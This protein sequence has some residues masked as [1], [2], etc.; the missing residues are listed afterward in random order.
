MDNR[1]S[2]KKKTDLKEKSSHRKD[3]M[4]KKNY[5]Q[6]S[7]DFKRRQ[8]NSHDRQIFESKNKLLG[9]GSSKPKQLKVHKVSPQEKV[10]TPF[11]NIS[12]GEDIIVESQKQFPKNLKQKN[13]FNQKKVCFAEHLG[14][15]KSKTK[16]R[17]TKKVCS[18][19]VS[20]KKLSKQMSKVKYKSNF[21]MSPSRR[22]FK[23]KMDFSPRKLLSQTRSSFGG[24]ELSI[25]SQKR[26]SNQLRLNNLESKKNFCV[27]MTTKEGRF[28]R[29]TPVGCFLSNTFKAGK[30]N[31]NLLR[32]QFGNLR[33]SLGIKTQLSS[34]GKPV[35]IYQDIKKS[36]KIPKHRNAF[37]KKT[38]V[39]EGKSKEKVASKFAKKLK[40]EELETNQE[41]LLKEGLLTKRGCQSQDQTG[42]SNISSVNINQIN[43]NN[44][45]TIDR[46]F[47]EEC[48]QKLINNLGEIILKSSFENL[49]V[50]E[51]ETSGNQ[52]KEAIP[53]QQRRIKGDLD[54]ITLKNNI[55]KE[56]EKS[57]KMRSSSNKKSS[58]IKRRSCQMKSLGVNAMNIYCQDLENSATHVDRFSKTSTIPSFQA[59]INKENLKTANYLG[60]SEMN[61]LCVD[62]SEIPTNQDFV[63]RGSSSKETFELS[64]TLNQSKMASVSELIGK[65]E[66][67]KLNVHL[68]NEKVCSPQQQNLM[69]GRV[70]QTLVTEPKE[71]NL[72]SNDRKTKTQFVQK[73][74]SVQVKSN[75]K[76]TIGANEENVREI[77]RKLFTQEPTKGKLRR[78]RKL[79]ELKESKVAMTETFTQTKNV[80][81]KIYERGKEAVT[82]S[83]GR[84]NTDTKSLLETLD[85]KN[86]I[87]KKEPALSELDIFITEIH[88]KNLNRI[89]EIIPEKRKVKKNQIA[90]SLQISANKVDT[91]ELNE[92]V[93]YLRKGLSNKKKDPFENCQPTQKFCLMSHLTDSNQT[94]QRVPSQVIN[95]SN[96][97]RGHSAL[98]TNF[99]MANSHK[100][101]PEED[102]NESSTGKLT[103]TPNT[104]VNRSRKINTFPKSQKQTF[105][106]IPSPKQME[107]KENNIMS[108]TQR[109]LNINEIGK[110][111]SWLDIFDKRKIKDFN[112]QFFI[113]KFTLLLQVYCLVEK[114]KDFYSLLKTLSEMVQQSP[115]EGFN[116]FFLNPLHRKTDRKNSLNEDQSSRN[117]I[118]FEES[119]TL[120]DKDSNDENFLKNRES[121]QSP[122]TCPI[123]QK[124]SIIK[125]SI[126]RS[127]EL[128]TIS[129]LLLFYLFV[130]GAGEYKALRILELV[131]HSC[132]VFITM[133]KN[134][135]AEMQFTEK[136]QV[137]EK[138]LNE[139]NAVN[140]FRHI[141]PNTAEN[142]IKN[143]KVIVSQIEILIN[144][145]PQLKNQLTWVLSA[146]TIRPRITLK[147]S[148]ENIF[149]IFYDI[150][151]EKGLITLSGLDQLTGR[152]SHINLNKSFKNEEPNS[153]ESRIV[154]QSKNESLRQILSQKKVI[155]K[156]KVQQVTPTSEDISLTAHFD[157]QEN[158]EK[159][160]L[161][162]CFEGTKE[163]KNM[164]SQS[165]ITRIR[166]P[167]DTSKYERK[168]ESI[169]LTGKDKERLDALQS[170]ECSRNATHRAD[171]VVEK[172][173]SMANTSMK[174][175]N[176]S[177]NLSITDSGVG[178]SQLIGISLAN[179]RNSCLNG[180]FSF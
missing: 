138:F 28:P 4:L 71:Q 26:T 78:K 113:S 35:N 65:I 36:E 31:S 70:T 145:Y 101:D 21:K 85:E 114:K 59:E 146:Q 7:L 111:F 42:R 98:E 106:C 6:K 13:S 110:K 121:S 38:K 162:I 149:R 14:P 50:K 67:K 107:G 96:V 168:N 43:I 29:Q 53:D 129:I 89:E 159:Q 12:L 79:E 46:E 109:N 17:K 74:K 99:T 76:L 39:H 22:S 86:R 180:K 136:E 140:A 105:S 143:N 124:L 133:I 91:A 25:K 160:R 118:N 169:L 128:E 173:N 93:F 47:Y 132:Y 123:I 73:R 94:F 90:K 170:R 119:N 112:T 92:K 49:N 137:I 127:F 23:G 172:N 125:S 147:T 155:D 55:C 141:E 58:E 134:V 84:W 60:K 82:G 176:I 161:E 100:Q 165:E 16:K 68:K 117:N 83:V 88:E 3:L 24:L 156:P 154:E 103:S 56:F 15:I 81:L 131:A 87:P 30:G 34:Q 72:L 64:Q 177:K 158:L 27:A 80:E 104:K 175:I 95:I 115:F 61:N 167:K 41:A 54:L 151:A 142:L 116:T 164:L 62:Q 1:L 9:K 108:S 130:E 97:I 45:N 10:N 18:G 11:D 33:R 120:R 171:S 126:N 179:N 51:N 77:N 19:K 57:L 40:L 69:T 135:Y 20:L 150:L 5:Y 174:V 148:I 66:N 166:K 102:Q 8:S 37:K 163:L 178:H 2:R 152:E 157:T 63:F 48:K 52:S 44:I 32:R 144:G 139:S 153:Y 122:L 75:P